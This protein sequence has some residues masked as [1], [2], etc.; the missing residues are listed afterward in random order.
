MIGEKNGDVYI[1]LRTGMGDMKLSLHPAKWRMAL[2]KEAAAVRLKPDQDRVLSRWNHTP[3][4]ARGWRLAAT[5][6]VPTS[7]LVPAFPERSVNKVQ[8]FPSPGSGKSMR[9]IVLLGARDR[10]DLTVMNH[11]G[12]VGRISLASGEAVWVIAHEDDFGPALETQYAMLRARAIEGMA[13]IDEECYGWA[14]GE[15][16]ND[17]GP[18]LI[19]LSN[20]GPANRTTGS[21]HVGMNTDS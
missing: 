9:F 2:T 13:A 10:D 11:I 12:D 1:G 19:E 8:W 20:I 3:E 5:I 17:G 15:N 4:C 21:D 18:V 6:N 7:A 14:W 16:N